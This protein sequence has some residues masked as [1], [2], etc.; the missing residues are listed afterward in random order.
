MSEMQRTPIRPHD[1]VVSENLLIVRG[2]KV[3]VVGGFSSGF[4]DFSG[5]SQKVIPGGTGFGLK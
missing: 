1:Y 4:C 5:T 2:S 3:D